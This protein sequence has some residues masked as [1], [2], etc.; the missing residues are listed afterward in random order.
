MVQT[1]CTQC[2]GGGKMIKDPCD[3]CQGRGIKSETAVLTMLVPDGMDDGQTLRLPGKGDSSPGGVPGDLF[4]TL[5]VEGDPRFRREGFDVTSKVSISFVKA[6]L[7]GE[8]EIDT[9]DDS[10]KGTAILELAPGTCPGD[11]AVRR[12]QGV[13]H[14]GR[15]RGDHLI[16]FTIEVPKKLSSKQEKLLREFALESGEDKK[17]RRKRG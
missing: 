6:A 4:V 15:G 14:R 12:G 5:R 17:H 13:P 2:H 9:L 1:S 7:G 8:I 3:V 10:C 16:E 11:I